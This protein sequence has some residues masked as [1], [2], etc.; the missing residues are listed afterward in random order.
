MNQL[1]IPINNE[2]AKIIQTK[3]LQ[4]CEVHE[5]SNKKMIRI[6]RNDFKFKRICY[7][8]GY[9]YTQC[10]VIYEFAVFYSPKFL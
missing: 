8:K 10:K 9:M 3:S 1:T 5:T 2:I 4:K 6:Y 7:I